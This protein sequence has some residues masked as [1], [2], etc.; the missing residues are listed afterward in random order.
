MD[1]SKLVHHSLE[2]YI[3]HLAHMGLVHRL[4]LVVVYIHCKDLL[5]IQVDN[6]IA[7]GYLQRNSQHFLFE[8]N[9][10]V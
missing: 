10:I 6:S 8:E 9:G 5:K 2:Q 3:D 1:R 7:L 4:I